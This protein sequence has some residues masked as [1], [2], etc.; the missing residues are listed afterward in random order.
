MPHTEVQVIL[1]N[2]IAV[3]FSYRILDGDHISVYPPFQ[4]FDLEASGRLV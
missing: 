4:D 2:G 1:V 3:D